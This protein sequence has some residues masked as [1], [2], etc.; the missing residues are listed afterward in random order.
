MYMLQFL[1]TKITGRLRLFS[2]DDDGVRHPPLHSLTAADNKCSSSNLLPEATASIGFT[3]GPAQHP[4][5]VIRTQVKKH[6]QCTCIFEQVLIRQKAPSCFW[7]DNWHSDGNACLICFICFC[8]F[9]LTKHFKSE[10]CSFPGFEN[11][12]MYMCVWDR[13]LG[14]IPPVHPCCNEISILIVQSQV[15]LLRRSEA[16]GFL[17]KLKFQRPWGSFLWEYAGKFF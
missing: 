1:Y 6:V 10:Q 2:M 9:K 15:V 4:T 14:Y 16:C 13:T 8:S 11:G 5:L 3:G 12:T 17:S 7:L